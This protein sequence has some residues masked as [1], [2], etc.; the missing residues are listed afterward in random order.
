MMKRKTR[1]L[2]QDTVV[3]I[4]AIMFGVI[5]VF[6]LV[7]C[8]AG[9]FKTPAEFLTPNLL[10]GSFTYF[11]NFKEALEKGNLLRYTV[12]SFIIALAGTSI[13]LVFSIL[14]AFAF[15]HYDFKFKNLCFFLILGTMMI[16]ADV[17]LATNYLTVSR[18]HLLN[19]YVGVMVVSFVS[20][21]QMFMLRQRFM[22]VPKDMREAAQIDGYGDISYMINVLIPICKPV[23]TTLFVHSFITLWNAYLWPLIVTASSPDMRT[24]MVGITKLNSWEDENYQLV[25]AGVC[26]SLI[27][28]LILFI[29]MRRNM[30]RGGMDG[31]LVG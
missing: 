1:T 24:I 12:N 10:P 13:R 26:I 16:P 17:L 8:F 28:S 14:A 3:S 29:I 27:P 4:L 25:L 6:P 23:I 15:A 21:S 22:S 11:E 30:K 2:I 9:A 5:L 31:A 19:S 20:A 18:L 7:Y